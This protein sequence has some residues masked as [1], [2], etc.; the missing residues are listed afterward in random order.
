MK[1]NLGYA[2]L[3]AIL[4]AIFAVPAVSQSATVK[5]VCKDMDGKPIADAQVVWHNE[6]NGRSFPLKTNKKGEYF[7]LGLD[8]GTYTVTL[9][10]DGNVLD[11]VR[12]YKMGLEEH[13]LDFDLKQA[14][15]DTAKG[16][17]MTAEQAKQVQETR[18]GAE[19]YNANVKIVNDKLAAAL[20]AT[21]PSTPDYD[22]AL[23]LMNDAVALLP[24][25]NLV[26]YRRGVV[27]LDSAK[28]QTDPA[29]KTQRYTSAYNDFQKAIE[30]KKTAMATQPAKPTPPGG[31]PDKVLLANYYEN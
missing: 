10:K 25:E 23:A 29:E 9:T 13:T 5:G 7:S 6:E 27:Y 15:E 2:A 11:T 20:A 19:K 12:N 21:Q 24:N 4:C 18:A 22:K 8:S 31:V 26:W 3:L 17:G 1:R 30:L 28:I 16:Q 14:Q